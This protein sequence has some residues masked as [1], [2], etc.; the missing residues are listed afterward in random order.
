MMIRE[1]KEKTHVESKQT[2][3]E[4][5]NREKVCVIECEKKWG[6]EKEEEIEEEEE[7][8]IVEEEVNDGEKEE[9]EEEVSE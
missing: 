3:L 8:R 9:E 2:N 6:R 1:E 4:K 7:E 5:K